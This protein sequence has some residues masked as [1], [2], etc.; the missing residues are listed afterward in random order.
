MRLQG[1]PHGARPMGATGNGSAFLLIRRSFFTLTEGRSCM[2]SL[3]R[4]H[5]NNFRLF[6]PLSCV[7]SNFLCFF[8]PHNSLFGMSCASTSCKPPE[9]FPSRAS[10]AKSRYFSPIRYVRTFS[11][12]SDYWIAT[13]LNDLMVKEVAQVNC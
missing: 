9:F 2:C 6:P 4:I 3:L 7:A 13:K 8:P 11:D 5:L 10:P 1:K 12:T